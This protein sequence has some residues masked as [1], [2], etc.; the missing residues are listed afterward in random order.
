MAASRLKVTYTDGTEFEAKMTPKALVLIER[1]YGKTWPPIEG[2]LYAAFL[3][4]GKGGEFDAWLETVE[5]AEEYTPDPTGAT[6][7]EVSPA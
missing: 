6:P 5:D 3:Q 2:S 7:P 4:A 1:K